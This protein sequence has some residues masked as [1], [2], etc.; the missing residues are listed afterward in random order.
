LKKRAVLDT[1]QQKINGIKN[2]LK[3]KFKEKE[4]MG[5]NMIVT[6]L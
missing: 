1:I 2:N 3:F 4:E 5:L 6:N